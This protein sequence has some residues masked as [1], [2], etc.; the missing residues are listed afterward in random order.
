MSW[1]AYLNEVRL[2]DYCE[3]CGQGL[4]ETRREEREVGAWNY[5]RNVTP[6]IAAAWSIATGAPIEHNWWDMLNGLDGPKG[7]SHIATVIRALESDPH[8]FRSMNPPN[9]WGSYD[10]L[11]P[12]LRAMRDAVE[13]GRE[14]SWRTSG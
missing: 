5:T 4:P 12:V 14:Y 11:L 2:I 13:D 10:T 7:K 6:M 9:G 3:S 1:D 8:H